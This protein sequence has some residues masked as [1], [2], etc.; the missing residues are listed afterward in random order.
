MTTSPSSWSGIRR[1]SGPPQR[2]RRAGCLGQRDAPCIPRLGHVGSNCRPRELVGLLHL[3]ASIEVT[4]GLPK[5]LPAG[6]NL[7]GLLAFHKELRACAVVQVA[8][9]RRPWPRMW[10]DPAHK[11]FSKATCNH[12]QASA[13]VGRPA[14]RSPAK[15]PRGGHGRPRHPA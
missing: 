2:P 6:A 5:A 11:W 9:C 1:R 4:Q 13:S 14:P 12:V 10:L 3:P 15:S 7:N 8:G